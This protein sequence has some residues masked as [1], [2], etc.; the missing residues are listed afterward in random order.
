MKDIIGLIPAAGQGTRLALPFPK[1]LWPLP[2]LEKYVPVALRSV[3]VLRAAG[4]TRIVIVTSPAKSG[5]ME[6]FGDGSRF[7]VEFIYACQEKF[8]GKGKSAGLSQAL[9]CAY[10]IVG[11]KQVAFVMPDT[12]VYPT[13]CFGQLIRKAGDADMVLGLFPTDQPHKFGMVRTD[14]YRVEEIIDKPTKTDLRLMWGILLW[15]SRFSDHL[16][17]CM[18]HDAPDFTGVMNRALLQNLD[19]RAVEITD[20]KYLDFGT[21]GDVAQAET[22][23][24]RVKGGGNRIGS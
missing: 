15:S 19:V 4:I 22:F 1:E 6:Y 16:R 8:P 20:G 3:E 10:H 9:D 2:R 18:N 7:G 12:Y 14:G 13:D 21:Y 24:Q 23:F 11:S 17:A 5:I